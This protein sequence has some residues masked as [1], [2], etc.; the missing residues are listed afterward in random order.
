MANKDVQ[1]PR[2][3]PASCNRTCGNGTKPSSLSAVTASSGTMDARVAVCGRNGAAGLAEVDANAATAGDGDGCTSGQGGQSEMDEM[4]AGSE[5]GQTCLGGWGR[6][7]SI[8]CSGCA[9][10]GLLPSELLSSPLACLN[11]RQRDSSAPSS[12]ASRLHR[13]TFPAPLSQLIST[14]RAPICSL[15]L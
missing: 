6:S 8:R 14:D 13:H 7:A 9:S 5:E 1:H 4:E 3:G 12:A 10:F 11:H 2:A 15:V